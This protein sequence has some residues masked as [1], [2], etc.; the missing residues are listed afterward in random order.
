[1]EIF[2][3]LLLESGVKKLAA[4]ASGD[5]LVFFTYLWF[6]FFCFNGISTLFRLFNAKTNLLEEQ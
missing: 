5:Y 3:T 2:I 6:G 4:A 1:M